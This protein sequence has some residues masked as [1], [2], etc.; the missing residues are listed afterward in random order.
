MRIRA[1]IA[2]LLHAGLP[3]RAIARQLHVD[4]KTVA[5]ARAH[6]R[7]PKAKG[8]HKPAATPEDLF[9]RRVKPTS[10]GHLLWDGYRS[11]DGTLGLRHG[12]RFYTAHRLAFQIA[13]NREPVGRVTG[14]CERAGCVHPRCVED[15]PM[16][17]TY[18]AIFG[19]TS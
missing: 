19:R 7:L 13:N 18:A 5:A 4:A 8:G 2:E 3:D 1:D 11:K 9:W 16:R 10:D 6:L 14:G 12:G 17:D 15:Q